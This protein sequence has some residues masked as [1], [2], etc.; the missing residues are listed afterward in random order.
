[1][2][3][4]AAVISLTILTASFAAGDQLNRAIGSPK[5]RLYKQIDDARNW[6][7]PW[8]Y[9]LDDGVNVQAAGTNG[10]RHVPV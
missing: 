3:I 10:W 2:T 9:T 6:Q 7:N 4:H 8:I 5:P 1:V